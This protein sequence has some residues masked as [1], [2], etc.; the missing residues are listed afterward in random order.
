LHKEFVYQPVLHHDE[1]H[2]FKETAEHKVKNTFGETEA[3]VHKETASHIKNPPIVLA[4]VVQKHV[5]GAGLGL[6]LGGHGHGHHYG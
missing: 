1:V 4:P 5:G 3:H 2:K 6:G